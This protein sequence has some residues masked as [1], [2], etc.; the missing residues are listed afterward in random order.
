MKKIIISLFIILALLLVGCENV[1]LSKISSEDVDKVIVCNKPYMRFGSS[2]CLDQNENGVCDNDEKTGEE[3]VEEEEA[4][5]E[6]VGEET[7]EEEVEGSLDCPQYYGEI[8]VYVYDSPQLIGGYDINVNMEDWRKE[9]H[10]E[11]F[12]TGEK[13]TFCAKGGSSFDITVSKPGYKTKTAKVSTYHITTQDVSIYLEKGEDIVKTCSDECS[14]DRCSDQTFVACEMQDD[15]CK[16]EVWVGFVK[17]E[18][19][20]ECTYESDCNADENCYNLEC[21]KVVE[22][23]P[24]CYDECDLDLLESTDGLTCQN[25]VIYKCEQV[26]ECTELVYRVGCSDTAHCVITPNG[27]LGYTTYS[28]ESNINEGGVEEEVVEETV[29]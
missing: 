1:D 22:E 5:E 16:D 20:V 18:C 15:G 4:E 2:C 8:T 25:N 23:E 13:T 9:L 21:V 3:T 24:T 6:A 26:G 7:A 17:G 12:M 19:G 27:H 10:K 28:C 14:S 11:E 29:E